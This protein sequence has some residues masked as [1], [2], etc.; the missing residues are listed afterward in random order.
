MSYYY[1]TKEGEFIDSSKRIDDPKYIQINEQEYA[2][3]RLVVH[4]YYRHE[5]EQAVERVF[6]ILNP[7]QQSAQ[8]TVYTCETCGENL[9]CVNGM[10][11]DKG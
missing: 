7:A 8:S 4:G 6:S 2:I 10:C 5:I 1:I 3:T 11:A 9:Q